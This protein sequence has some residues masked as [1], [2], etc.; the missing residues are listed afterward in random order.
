MSAAAD[1]HDKDTIRLSNLCALAETL[2]PAFRD[3]YDFSDPKDFDKLA[4]ISFQAAEAMFRNQDARLAVIDATYE[5]ELAKENADAQAAIAK[6]K[7]ETVAVVVPK[8]EAA[9][10]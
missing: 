1:K 9:N 5:K 2:M 3:K 6:A 4:E 8:M 7:A 10:G